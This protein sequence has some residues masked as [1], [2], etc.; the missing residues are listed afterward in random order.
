MVA[1]NTEVLTA[2][3]ETALAINVHLT[4]KGLWDAVVVLLPKLRKI[5]HP[6]H[7]IEGMAGIMMKS[8]AFALVSIRP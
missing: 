4:F 3:L 2:I 1:Y 6:G 5:K 7:L 8:A